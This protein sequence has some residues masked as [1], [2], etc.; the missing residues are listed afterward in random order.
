M[1]TTKIFKNEPISENK[2]KIPKIIIVVVARL[3]STRLKNK[4]LIPINGLASI[5]CC[6][7]N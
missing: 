3:K 6:L 1:A 7:L 5:K 4:A 2:V